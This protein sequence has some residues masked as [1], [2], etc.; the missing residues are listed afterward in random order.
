MGLSADYPAVTMNDPH[1]HVTVYN[2]RHLPIGTLGPTP[3]EGPSVNVTCVLV[4]W[5]DEPWYR[6]LNPDAWDFPAKQAYVSALETHPL[7]PG[8][9]YHIPECR[10]RSCVR[11]AAPVVAA[12][13]VAASAAAWRRRR[14]R[15]S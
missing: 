4:E 3:F 5:E 8:E 11:A 2:E 10:D 12:G 9:P 6:L 1:D 14:R 13:G 7:N 15:S